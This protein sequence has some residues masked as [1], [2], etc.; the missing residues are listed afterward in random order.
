M[1]DVLDCFKNTY[2]K[3]FKPFNYHF[4]LLRG[5]GPKICSKHI[6]CETYSVLK[7]PLLEFLYELFM[8]TMVNPTSMLISDQFLQDQVCPITKC[9]KQVRICKKENNTNPFFFHILGVPDNLFY[10]KYLR[11][12]ILQNFDNTIRK[13]H[14]KTNRMSRDARKPVFGV[15]D[16]VGH[17]PTC[18]LTEAG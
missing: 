10:T 18:T 6:A 11:L 17:K 1:K 2:C 5:L 15:S 16:Q 13:I 3:P 9:N 4:W 12:N 7:F 14:I 8:V